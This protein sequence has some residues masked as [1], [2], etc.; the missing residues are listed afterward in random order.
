MKTTRR[1]PKV[2]PARMV[3]R[4]L[5]ALL[6]LLLMTTTALAA[7]PG[8]TGT[9]VG[10]GAGK[11]VTLTNP[12]TKQTATDFAGVIHLQLDLNTPGDRQGPQVNAF[13]VQINVM[14]R[15]GDGYNKG[16]PITGTGNCQIRYLLA[17]YPASTATTNDEAAARQVAI[18]HYTDNLDLTT[19]QDLPVRDR[20]AALVAE[21]DA[22]GCPNVSS[23]IPTMTISPP[24]ATVG[25]GQPQTYT[26]QVTPPDAAPNV[27][28]QINGTATFQ[29]GG[30]QATLPLNQG[31]ATFTVINGPT[32]PSTI[33]ASLPYQLDPGTI[34]ESNLQPPNQRLVLADAAQLTQTAQAT[35]DVQVV[36]DTPT[37]TAPPTGTPPT[38]TPPTDTPT[39]TPPTGTPPTDTPTATPPTGTPP[40]DT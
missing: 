22:A 8:L 33:T 24:T 19:V 9:L 17:T 30:Q 38:G 6:A 4:T 2:L 5:G 20:A 37:S 10:T 26:V 34:Y 25:P 1:L 35:I 31:A 18:W 23:T 21:A 12:V 11:R 29:G 39:A 7:S 3:W 15:V 32:G 36:T 13:C 27:T 40:T 16:D 14:T 28:L